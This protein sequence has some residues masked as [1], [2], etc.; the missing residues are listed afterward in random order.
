MTTRL[1]GQQTRFLPFNLGHNLGAGNPPNPHGHKTSYLWERVWARDAWLDILHRFIDVQ[2]PEKGTAA[3]KLAAAAGD[4]PPLPPVGRGA[5][6]RGRRARA[7]RRPVVPDPALGRVGEV[8]HDRMDCAPALDAA[9]RRGSEGV[10]QGGGDHRPGR[11]RPAAAGD[12]LPVR[13]RARGGR[14]DRRETPQQL[15]DALAGE[16]ARI[17]ITTLQKFPFV[18]DKVAELPARTYAVIVDEAHSS[19]GGEAAKDLRVALGA[20]RGA[21]ADRRRGR[22]RRAARR[23]GRSGGGGAGPA[24][25]RPEGRPVEPVVLRVHRD[26][27]GP[28]AR[29]VRAR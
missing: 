2:R 10:R 19:Q 4:L 24:G 21:G 3:Q 8:E 15:A 22:G 1:E 5:E 28:D 26:P 20:S 12:D 11:A 14:E 29:D 27:E 13:A 18:L 7:R 9:R 25:R 23:G 16:Q 17:I 6:A